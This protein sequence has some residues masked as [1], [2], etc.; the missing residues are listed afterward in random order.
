MSPTRKT[1]SLYVA[2]GQPSGI[3]QPRGRIA[4][5]RE[6]AACKA[7]SLHIELWFRDSYWE[8]EGR[9]V[10]HDVRSLRLSFEF[11]LGGSYQ[12]AGVGLQ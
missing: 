1:F 10:E 9:N 8:F 12:F 3:L 5:D 7:N 2:D 11:P 6:K 4:S